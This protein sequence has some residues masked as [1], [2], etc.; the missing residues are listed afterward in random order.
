VQGSRSLCLRRTEI[1]HING[2]ALYSLDRG[3]TSALRKEMAKKFDSWAFDVLIGHWLF[4]AHPHRIRES[5]HVL[6]IS[7]FQRNRTC[8]EMVRRLVD[9]N[10]QAVRSVS[11]AL[12]SVGARPDLYL[13]HTGNLFKLRDSAVPPSMRNLGLALQDLFVPRSDE[14][15]LLESTLP[16]DL[17]SCLAHTEP[18]RARVKGQAS[19]CRLSTPT[20][21]P[22]LWTPGDAPSNLEL[23]R[24][25]FDTVELVEP[26][27][28]GYATPDSAD[29][30]ISSPRGV[31][32]S[33]L[34]ALLAVLPQ[35]LTAGT[36]GQLVVVL[37]RPSMLLWSAYQVSGKHHSFASWL[38]AIGSDPIVRALSGCG[39]DK[40]GTTVLD[41]PSIL[42]RA[43]TVLQERFLVV[44]L[45]P[46]MTHRSLRLLGAFFQWPFERPPLG[47]LP[48]SEDSDTP[49]EEDEE[50]PSTEGHEVSADFSIPHLRREHVL[51]S[52]INMAGYTAM[53]DEARSLVSRRTMLD[54]RLFEFAERLS[55]EQ[56]HSA[57][58]AVESS[59]DTCAAA[60]VAGEAAGNALMPVV[61][62]AMDDS[63]SF[64][65]DGDAYRVFE[66]RVP[67][68]GHS[69][70]LQ[71]R[72]KSVIGSSSFT[73]NI[74]VSHRTSKPSYAERTWQYLYK[75]KPPHKRAGKFMLSSER[76]RACCLEMATAAGDGNATRA[77]QT[78]RTISLFVAF[79]C[80]SSAVSQ[81]AVLV[82]QPAPRG[83]RAYT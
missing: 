9:Y 59:G 37:S 38:D 51:G 28:A 17:S 52:V 14:P 27:D 48:P 18:W 68:P 67:P 60:E 1:E 8:C 35:L 24:Q 58:W 7:T 26:K 5:P 50:T 61:P 6:S 36:S 77:C 22:L 15:C 30:R 44:A 49:S 21:V 73:V 29:G 10:Q 72:G 66:V 47:M 33:S 55:D 78:S 82:T 74:L 65:W 70:Q 39:T 25:S 23:I 69:M 80:R 43:K 71:V 76:L 62:L 4:R 83:S 63:T 54:A 79:K 32:S 16:P 34:S 20:L 12:S 46:N 56:Y 64:T 31:V 57:I 13:L 41:G 53:P 19:D 42:D 11:L 3:F 45:T 75:S 2:N 81:L 40:S